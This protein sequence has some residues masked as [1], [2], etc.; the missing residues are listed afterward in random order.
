MENK[1]NK[2]IINDLK[3]KLTFDSPIYPKRNTNKSLLDFYEGFTKDKKTIIKDKEI[4]SIANSIYTNS[5]FNASSFNKSVCNFRKT[6]NNINNI[7]RTHVLNEIEPLK[8]KNNN[9]KQNIFDLNHSNTNPINNEIN[10]KNSMNKNNLNKN[11]LN[12]NKKIIKENTE[13]KTNCTP[14]IF[15]KNLNFKNP[16]NENKNNHIKTKS[17]NIDNSFKKSENNEQLFSKTVNNN[18]YNRNNSSEKKS[19]S[20]QK[21]FHIGINKNESYSSSKNSVKIY[22][23]ENNSNNKLDNKI[24]KNKIIQKSTL[25]ILLEENLREKN[26]DNNISDNLKFC[27]ISEEDKIFD[28]L[29]QFYQNEHP[30]KKLFRNILNPKV[31]NAMDIHNKNVLT[32]IYKT[33]WK[34]LKNIKDAKKKKNIDLDQYQSNLINQIGDRFR[35]DTIC[36]LMDSMKQLKFD[37]ISNSMPSQNKFFDEV[38][39]TEIEIIHNLQ[40]N[41]KQLEKLKKLARISLTQPISETKFRRLKRS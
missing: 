35:K 5:N 33:D 37:V 34:Y 31:D 20:N 29:A 2:K 39:S 24:P 13:I 1:N 9:H 16:I 25:D 32:K 26:I 17:F 27:L 4:Q 3:Y 28:D 21:V 14:N 36:K 10:Y 12:I 18:F 38:E 6:S 23:I 15:S 11:S 40:E 19:K 41:K 22:E 7:I 8:L 30:G